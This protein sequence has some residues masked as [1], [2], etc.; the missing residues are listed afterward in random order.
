[1]KRSLLFAAAGAVLFSIIPVK[2]VDDAYPPSENGVCEIRT[3]PAA[4]VIEAPESAPG[5]ETLPEARRN[6]LFRKLFRYIDTNDI[7]M[8]APVEVRSDSVRAGMIFYLGEDAAAREDLPSDA[9]VKV[10]RLPERTVAVLAVRGSYTPE[11]YESTEKTLRAWLEQRKDYRVVGPAYGV[12]WNSP[13][14]P[15]YFK[16]SEVHIPV[17][18]ALPAPATPAPKPSDSA[19]PAAPAK[20]G[21]R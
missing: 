20:P 5:G 15:G 18:P 8:T 9:G 19:P 10:T 16:K 13:F 12:Y 14:M 11:R 17:A 21:S 4:R 3:L 2:A 6:A 7:A 1:M